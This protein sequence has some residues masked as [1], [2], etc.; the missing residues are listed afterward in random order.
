VCLYEAER[1]LLL[2]GDVL[3]RGSY[4]RTDL[5]GGDDAQMVASLTRLL[6]EIP[7]ETRVLPGHGPETTL[8][9]EAAWLERLAAAGRLINPG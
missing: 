7:P 8:G 2:S 1:R 6:H 4:G 5:A 3:F 9:A